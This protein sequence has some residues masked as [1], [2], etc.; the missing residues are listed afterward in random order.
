MTKIK[1]VSEM[2]SGDKNMKNEEKFIEVI[3]NLNKEYFNTNLL[4]K[5]EYENGVYSKGKLRY[6]KKKDYVNFNFGYMMYEDHGDYHEFEIYE[7]KA[8]LNQKIEFCI[9]KGT[10]KISLSS[11]YIIYKFGDNITVSQRVYEYDDKTKDIIK[12]I[13]NSVNNLREYKL[14]D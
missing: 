7:N 3:E 12:I 13:I 6:E 14:I 10:K 8:T 11:V 2:F 4:L 5:V 1:K 9:D